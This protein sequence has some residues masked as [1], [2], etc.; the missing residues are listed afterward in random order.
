MR[1]DRRESAAEGERKRD[2]VG[3]GPTLKEANGSSPDSVRRGLFKVGLKFQEPIESASCDDI[4]RP[5]FDCQSSILRSQRSTPSLTTMLSILQ[6]REVREKRSDE[7]GLLLRG[8]KERMLEEFLGSRAVCRRNEWKIY[9]LYVRTEPPTHRGDGSFCKQLSIIDFIALLYLYF[10]P[11]RSSSGGSSMIVL[12]SALAGGKSELGA[13]P[14][15]NSS[16]VMPND[17]MS[18]AKPAAQRQKGQCYDRLRTSYLSSRTLS[19][20]PLRAPSSKA[21]PRSSFSAPSSPV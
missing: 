7:E 5:A 19:V 3:D 11:S 15:A 10:P 6:R 17:Q 18:A 16:A 12:L 20:Q 9:A 13:R 14:D 2:P 4:L 8:A 21:C 1:T